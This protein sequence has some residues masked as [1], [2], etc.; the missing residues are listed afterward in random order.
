[1]LTLSYLIFFYNYKFKIF[2]TLDVAVIAAT[3]YIP[4]SELKS[5]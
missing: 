3:I 4:Q 5:Q 2:S 1:M